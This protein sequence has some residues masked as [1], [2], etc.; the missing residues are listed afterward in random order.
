MTWEDVT[1]AEVRQALTAFRA[2]RRRAGRPRACAADPGG[3]DRLAALAAMAADIVLARLADA[4]RGDGA[5]GGIAPDATAAA[6]RDFS[7]G[8]PTRETWSALYHR[9]V[10]PEPFPLQRLAIT[11]GLDPLVGRRQLHRR[12][13]HGVRLVMRDIQGLGA[14]PAPSVGAVATPILA[15][16]PSF[17]GPFVGARDTLRDLAER[18]AEAPLLTVVGPPG[19]GKSRLVR[20]RMRG[21]AAAFPGGVAWVD[22]AAVASQPALLA[23]VARGLGVPPAP[24]GRQGTAGAVLE[25]WPLGRR[26]LVV[27][28]NADHL[29]DAA[30][31]V[32]G[33]VLA[34]SRDA[35]VVA[36]SR[37]R[38]NVEGEQVLRLA[39]WPLP[40]RAGDGDGPA[41]DDASGGEPGTLWAC[42]AADLFMRVLAARRATVRV[43]PAE[44]PA[45]VEIL[46]HT[47]GLPLVIER[48]AAAA[49]AGGIANLAARLA[50]GGHLLDVVCARAPARQASLRAVL[51]QATAR[52]DADA[53]AVFDAV[54]GFDGP[55]TLHEAAMAELPGLPAGHA[56]SRAALARHL[57]TLVEHALVLPVPG[58][59][60]AARFGVPRPFRAFGRERR[61]E[62]PRFGAVAAPRAP[63]AV[64][65]RSPGRPARRT[66]VYH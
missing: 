27:L 26:V 21:L 55:F 25:T 30:A 9:F 8:D 45:V 51:E 43:T 15:D 58:D 41:S 37:E 6:R 18:L 39:P 54:C 60:G 64:A 61:A 29:A 32:A 57:A 40:G 10:A 28:D 44:A 19:A 56:E 22:V 52:V 38:L 7:M 11:A 23:A 59:G 2:A 3:A 5:D 20:E 13:R 63:G 36:T 35:R 47:G 50:G 42:D 31:A 12:I 49:A 33:H 14:A 24:A 34:G 65:A 53:R 17:A 16:L 48:A 62:A 66:T 46:R 1:E 4:R